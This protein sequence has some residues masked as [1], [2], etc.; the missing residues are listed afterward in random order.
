M[1]GDGLAVLSGLEV[2]ASAIG[3]ARSLGEA[4]GRRAADGGVGVHGVGAFRL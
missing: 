1:C 3:G 2:R 4:G